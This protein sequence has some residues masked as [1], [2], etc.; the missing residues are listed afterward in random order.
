VNKRDLRKLAAFGDICLEEDTN[1]FTN[2][3]Y[4]KEY[5]C[6]GSWDPLEHPGQLDMLENKMIKEA[7]VDYW[8]INLGLGYW[9]VTYFNRELKDDVITAADGKT[10]KKARVEAI[11]KYT[12]GK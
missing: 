1:L 10:T 5:Q 2:K 4:L 11:L 12:R 3:K 7:G 6:S 8:E 9:T